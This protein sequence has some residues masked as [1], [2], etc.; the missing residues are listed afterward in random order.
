LEEAYDEVWKRWVKGE[1]G[2]VSLWCVT[3]NKYTLWFRI[4]DFSSYVVIIYFFSFLVSDGGFFLC[5][6]LSNHRT[7]SEFSCDDAYVLHQEFFLFHFFHVFVVGFIPFLGTT[8]RISL[9]YFEIFWVKHLALE[10]N[11]TWRHWTTGTDICVPHFN[12]A[13]AFG[14]I[15]SACV[16]S[17]LDRCL[18]ARRHFPFSFLFSRFCML[19]LLCSQSHVLGCN[20]GMVV[21]WSLIWSDPTMGVST[22]L[23]CLPWSCPYDVDVWSMLNR[24]CIS[25]C[26]GGTVAHNTR[27]H[28]ESVFN[29]CTA[30]IWVNDLFHIFLGGGMI[31]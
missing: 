24:S 30:H 18:M 17:R 23:C 13:L 2:D 8:R 6:H 9:L 16:V 31:M 14:W 1:E 3:P 4:S 29:W 26:I 5:S 7:S 10:G 15:Q 12:L 19:C 20:L 25:R 21:C 22:A 28:S 27:S 11:E